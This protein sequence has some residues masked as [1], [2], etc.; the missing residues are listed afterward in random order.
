MTKNGTTLTRILMGSLGAT[1]VVC[2]LYF[3]V[4]TV[5]RLATGAIP[6]RAVTTVFTFAFLFCFVLSGVVWIRMAL[7]ERLWNSIS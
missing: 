1:W 5:V 7:S 6:P 4:A 3:I 2:G